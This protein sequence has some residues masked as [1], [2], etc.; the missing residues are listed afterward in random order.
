M[1]DK[2]E[3]IRK[4]VKFISVKDYAEKF[5]FSEREIRRRCQHRR[6]KAKKSKGQW[7]IVSDT[8]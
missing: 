6:L 3:M 5:H 7:L 2:V 4:E 1:G 8:Q